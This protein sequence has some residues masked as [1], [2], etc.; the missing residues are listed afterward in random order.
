[1]TIYCLWC[2][3]DIE[4]TIDGRCPVCDSDITNQLIDDSTVGIPVKQPV[5][6]SSEGACGYTPDGIVQDLDDLH[7]TDSDHQ[8][9]VLLQDELYSQGTASGQKVQYSSATVT[10]SIDYRT[11]PFRFEQDTGFSSGRVLVTD[12]KLV[13]ILRSFLPSGETISMI[14]SKAA[15]NLVK[16]RNNICQRF[17]D[18]DK[19]SIES[20]ILGG[21]FN[22]I[23]VEDGF[24][25][26]DDSQALFKISEWIVK[27]AKNRGV[28][29]ILLSYRHSGH[30]TLKDFHCL[31]LH[32]ERTTMNIVLHG[33][34]CPPFHRINFT[35]PIIK[36]LFEYYFTLTNASSLWAFH[37]KASFDNPTKR[38]KRKR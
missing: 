5:S 12:K 33:K 31:T 11:L 30:N 23:P 10:E 32:I 15:L 16:F 8:I 29:D 18:N 3:K 37:R 27:Q 19:S 13:E 22:F 7:L 17:L 35:A 20:L 38:G 36:A 26:S 21:G 34:Q 1:M 4:I 2:Q 9:A 24:V 14:E 28:L 25:E 6:T